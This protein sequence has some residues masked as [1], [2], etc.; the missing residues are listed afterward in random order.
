[1]IDIN[2]IKNEYEIKSVNKE[3][4]NILKDWMLDNSV[5]EYLG[6]N[7][8]EDILKDR[9]LEYYITQNECFFMIYKNEKIVSIFKGRVEEDKIKK[10]IIW[11]FIVD[12]NIRNLGTGSE[13]VK[14][15]I[16]YFKIQHGI[17]KVEVGVVQNNMEG[18]SFWDSIGFVVDRVT[19][20]FFDKGSGKG[21]N[22]V[23]MSKKIK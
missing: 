16:E 18:I 9:F 13:L 8:D 11:F 21:K 14:Q 10:L 3:N 6:L 7:L 17:E 23:I 12:K 15:I 19:K 4:L 20:D 2:I 5:S 22:L 1:M